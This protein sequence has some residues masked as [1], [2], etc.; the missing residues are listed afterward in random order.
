MAMTRALNRRP[1][2]GD[3]TEL[4]LAGHD[5]GEGDNESNIDADV[6]HDSQP[7]LCPLRSRVKGWP[8]WLNLPPARS[9]QTLGAELAVEAW[10]RYRTWC[11]R[12]QLW[13]I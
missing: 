1:Q 7:T 2:K 5:L 13:T 3:R 10:R 8:I 12:N 6:G 11:V 9:I 4:L